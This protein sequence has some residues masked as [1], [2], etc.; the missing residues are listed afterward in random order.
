LRVIKKKREEIALLITIR[1]EGMKDSLE[2]S[3]SGLAIIPARC[4]VW[5]T[6]M[7]LSSGEETPWFGG[8]VASVLLYRGTSLIRKCPPP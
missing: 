6:F 2:A 7:G 4:L 3:L 8:E 5:P 1:F